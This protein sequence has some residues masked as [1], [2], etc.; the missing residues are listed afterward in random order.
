MRFFKLTILLI[1]IFL[2]NGCAPKQLDVAS[3]NPIFKLQDQQTISVYET[4]SETILFYHFFLENGV[5]MSRTW[6]KIL[7]YHVNFTDL[8]ITGM[9]HDLRRVTDNQAETLYDALIFGAR[10]KGLISLHVNQEDYLL[11]V[12]FATKM[13]DIINAYEEKMRR[14]EKKREF[15][16]LF[17]K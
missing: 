2:L 10:Q 4:K 14:Y 12:D 8:W 17:Q 1:S 5:W 9:G 16:F 13:V 3:I 15:P 7:P 6:G 11:D